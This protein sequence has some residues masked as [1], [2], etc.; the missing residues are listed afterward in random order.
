MGRYLA[1]YPRGAY[2]WIQ[3]QSYVRRAVLVLVMC[4]CSWASRG[5]VLP[6]VTRG[7][8]DTHTEMQPVPPPCGAGLFSPP[9]QLGSQCLLLSKCGRLLFSM[10]N[11]VSSSSPFSL[12]PPSSFSSDSSLSHLC[13]PPSRLLCLPSVLEQRQSEASRLYLC[14]SWRGKAVTENIVSWKYCNAGN[15][16]NLDMM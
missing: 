2:L 5:V 8:Q 7:R 11:L 10:Q 4:V 9:L 14:S 13:F 12:L 3:Q 6:Q 16:D 15:S 1:K